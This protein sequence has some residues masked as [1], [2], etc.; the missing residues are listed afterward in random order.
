M[1]VLPAGYSVPPVIYYTGGPVL[2]VGFSA[3][4]A[5]VPGLAGSVAPWGAY[6]GRIFAK[7]LFFREHVRTRPPL[8]ALC[9][10]VPASAGR[11]AGV[12]LYWFESKVL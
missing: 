1:P 3:G 8:S 10:F 6:I 11:V 2:P 4:P 12:P 7:K 5:S 9:C